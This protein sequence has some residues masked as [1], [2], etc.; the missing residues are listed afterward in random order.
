MQVCLPGQPVQEAEDVE[1]DVEL[2]YAPEVVVCLLPD[3]RV[4]EDEHGAHDGEQRDAGQPGQRLQGH[5]LVVIQLDYSGLTAGLVRLIFRK[6]PGWWAPT[7]A[8]S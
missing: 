4:R 5:N 7:V 8:A 6:F 3:R 2:V 1:E